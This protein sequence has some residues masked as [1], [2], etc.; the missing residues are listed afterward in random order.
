MTFDDRLSFFVQNFDL[1]VTGTYSSGAKQFISD[2][3]TKFCRFCQKDETKTTFSNDSHAIPECLGNHQ[4]ILLNECDVCNKFFSETLE[5]HLD[6]FTKPYR[7]VGQIVGKNGVPNYRTNNKKNR[8]EFN[9]LPTVKSQIGEDFFTIDHA[10]NELTIKLHQES[11]IPLAVYKAL[12]KVA[13]SIIEKKNELSAFR[14]TI[15]WLL[16]KDL[17]ISVIK[18]A[19]LMQTFIPGPRPTKG[20]FVS[21][22]RRKSNL[23]GVPYAIFV[24]AFG[25]VVFQVI[26]PSHLDDGLSIPNSIPFFPTPFEINDWPYGELK[27]SL[28]DLSGTQKI[29][30]EFPVTYSFESSN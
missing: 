1:I 28:C 16:N 24:I 18:P 10:K 15:D 8:I 13:I 5:D 20:V 3:N 19:L 4:L 21:L 12:L 6:K 23:S 17:T 9:D 27:F 7:I 2:G 29:E 14:L 30:R 25:N 26:V 22:F 11:H